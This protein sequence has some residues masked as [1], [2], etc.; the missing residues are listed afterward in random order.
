MQQPLEQDITLLMMI[1]PGVTRAE[2]VRRIARAA[3]REE[4]LRQRA[5]AGDREAI[6]QF[7]TEQRE[8][9][10]IIARAEAKAE[11]QMDLIRGGS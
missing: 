3:V 8:L 1:N 2:V 6:D 4:L 7:R 11:S 5:A 10:R 9:V